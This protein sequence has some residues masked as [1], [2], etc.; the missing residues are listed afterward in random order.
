MADHRQNHADSFEF[1]EKM[2]RLGQKLIAE[3][4]VVIGEE[5]AKDPKVL[6]L[7]LL[8]RLMSGFQG[9]ILLI[10][11]GMVVEARTLA[12]S[13]Y[14]NMYCLVS[15]QKFGSEFSARMIGDDLASRKATANWLL[16]REARLDYAGADAAKKLRETV[17][18]ID[19]NHEN[20]GRHVFEQIAERAEIG[21]M[22][23]FYRQL[24]WDAAHPSLQAL[25]RYVLEHQ[26]GTPN[27]L[28]WGPE[29]DSDEIGKTLD[30]TLPGMFAA[31]VAGSELVGSGTAPPELNALWLEYKARIE[32][33]AGV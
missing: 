31:L 21:D 5:G 22:Y 7:L 6:A 26:P 9:V 29:C 25:S 15:L 14:E 2:N 23:M 18:E 11:R 13:C 28:R 30:I 32:R 4:N 8:L 20:I 33:T 24:S 27:E 12:R 19:A 17:Y 16:Q 1:A 10:E 3:A